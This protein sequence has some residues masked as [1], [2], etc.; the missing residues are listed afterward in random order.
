MLELING[1]ADLSEQIGHDAVKLIEALQVVVVKERGIAL[2]SVAL[3]AAR[4][5]V[6]ALGLDGHTRFLHV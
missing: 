6:K 3:L 5:K 1:R 4:H 2:E